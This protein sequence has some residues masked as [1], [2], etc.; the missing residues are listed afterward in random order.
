MGRLGARPEALLETYGPALDV[1][2]QVLLGCTPGP[3]C[4]PEGKP[5]VQRLV[6][7]PAAITP[8]E[9][10]KLVDVGGPLGTAS[11][12]AQTFLRHERDGRE[13]PRLGR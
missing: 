4:P 2:Q 13:R 9:G 5:V 12:L 10:E 1:M 11:T 6:D 3:A 7:L 8:G